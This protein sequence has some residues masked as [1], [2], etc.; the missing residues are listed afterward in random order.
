MALNGQVVGYVRVSSAGQHLDRQIVA[1]GEVDR[2]FTE[3][4]PGLSEDGTVVICRGAELAE[5]RICLDD[6]MGFR[7]CGRGVRDRCPGGGVS[8]RP[9]R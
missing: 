8:V 7:S 5:I 1:V 6:R 2:L 4:N 3:A 9:V